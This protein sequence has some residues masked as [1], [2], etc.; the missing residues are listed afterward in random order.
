MTL[1]LKL[2][3]L[4][5]A[6]L[7]AT[8][9]GLG[10]AVAMTMSAMQYDSID[11]NLNTAVAVQRVKSLTLNPKAL[12]ADVFNTVGFVLIDASGQ[13]RILRPAGFGSDPLPFPNLEPQTVDAALQG[14]VSVD[15]PVPYRLVARMPNGR[16]D[17]IVALTPLNVVQAQLDQLNRSIGLAVVVMV[18]IG[19]CFEWI[20]IGRTLRPVRDMVGAAQAIAGGDLER[21]LPNVRP[22]TEMGDL[23]RALNEMISALTASL[24]GVRASE[25]RLR[26]F[27]SDASHELRTPLTVIRGYCEVLEDTMPDATEIQSRAL[28]RISTESERLQRL[29]SELLALQRA[30]AA[31]DSEATTDLAVVFREAFESFADLNAD[32]T[33]FIDVESALVRGESDIWAQVAGNLTQNIARYTPAESGVQMTIRTRNGRCVATIDDE[34]PGVP[35][36]R[37]AQMLER[38]TRLDESRSAETGGAGL[39]L[40]IVRAIVEACGGNV[41]LADSPGGGLQVILELPLAD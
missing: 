11:D 33:V 28:S 34:G 26:T 18:A 7:L 2:M 36:H 5:T 29:V 21:R 19:A 16:G 22:A 12:P 6:V 4:T 20:I 30:S 13:Q 17:V 31:L 3:L 35:L 10:V 23:A 24:N 39:G 8:S 40:S 37:R 15:G 25:D 14:G 32:R 27:V 38:F 41:T 1:R 9:T